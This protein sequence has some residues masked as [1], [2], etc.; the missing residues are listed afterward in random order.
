MTLGLAPSPPRP[1]PRRPRPP[2][3]RPARSGRLR[4]RSARAA[5]APLRPLSETLADPR[6]QP[7]KQRGCT[8]VTVYAAAA[9][10][11]LLP[12]PPRGHRRWILHGLRKREKA[13]CTVSVPLHGVRHPVPRSA[14]SGNPPHKPIRH[15]RACKRTQRTS[16]HVRRLTGRSALSLNTCLAHPPS[17]LPRPRPRPPLQLHGKRCPRPRPPL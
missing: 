7:S 16:R 9:A 5:A 6:P 11:A 14:R 2:L 1:A 15:A 12:L 13:A 3:P 4:S 8:A 10:S 17:R